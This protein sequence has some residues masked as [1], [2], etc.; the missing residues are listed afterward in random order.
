[1]TRYVIQDQH[2]RSVKKCLSKFGEI[3]VS[4]NFVQGKVRILNYRKYKGRAEVDVLFTGKVKVRYPI[5]SGFCDSSILNRPGI[6][7]TR[8]NHI[9]RNYL[10]PE[11]KHR[12]AYFSVDLNYSGHIKKIKWESDATR[13]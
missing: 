11:I 8:V 5:N 3:D 13:D 7:K 6:S 2:W 4:T 9:L 10:F 12:M 1:M